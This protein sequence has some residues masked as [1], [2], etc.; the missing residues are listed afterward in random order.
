MIFIASDHAG[1]ELKEA[2]KKKLSGLSWKDLGT[3]SQDS[4]DYPD[5]AEKLCLEVLKDASHLGILI[6]G[7]GIGMSIAANKVRGIRA[8]T[9]SEEF[10]ARMA[11]EHNYAQVLCFGSRVVNTDLAV[12]LIEA[13]LGAQPDASERHARR[14]AKIESIESKNFKERQGS[15]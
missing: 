7:T 1:F 11:R 15:R 13:F 10:S 2:V 9:V 8:A 3:A 5:F 4:C 6:C 14:V 12:R